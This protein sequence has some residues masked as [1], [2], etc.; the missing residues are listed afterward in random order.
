MPNHL[1]HTMVDHASIQRELREQRKQKQR[2]PLIPEK[3]P[4]V[5][6][7]YIWDTKQRAWL[8]AAFVRMQRVTVRR[9]NR[10]RKKLKLAHDTLV[11]WVELFTAARGMDTRERWQSHPSLRP[12]SVPSDIVILPP[13]FRR[14]KRTG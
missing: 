12:D 4:R 5:W 10:W 14:M 1:H 11:R 2:D 9:V 13:R 8:L 7:A 3:A 6:V